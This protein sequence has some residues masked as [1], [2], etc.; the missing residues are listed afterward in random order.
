MGN[1][2]S[3]PPQHSP[4][5]V[6]GDLENFAFDRLLNDGKFMKSALCTYIPEGEQ[7]IVKIYAKRGR[8]AELEQVKRDLE[9]LAK[10]CHLQ[11]AP[12]LIPYQ[13]VFEK[14]VKR[15]SYAFLVRQHFRHN[16]CDRLQTRPVL[17]SV[18]KVW[19]VYQLLQ[20]VRQS[21]DLG[22]AHGDIKSENIV[23]TSW[24]WLFLTDFAVFKP[25]YLTDDNPSDY[26]YFF[27][28]E[29]RRCYLAP[30]R[31]V[32]PEH[33]ASESRTS[34]DQTEESKQTGNDGGSSGT[35]SPHQRS[36]AIGTRLGI[37]DKGWEWQTLD[38][39][40]AGCTIGEVMLGDGRRLFQ[41]G[42][43]LRYRKGELSIDDKLSDIKDSHA[44]V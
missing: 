29:R 2:H 7:V 8:R 33:G 9:V 31:F 12:N 10:R 37:P 44:R 36:G 5:D 41:Y 24:G 35:H 17:S 42:E 20:A 43:L 3:S 25:F 30:E 16:L 13:Q 26:V 40:S 27:D 4:V 19:L 11:L 38:I 32:S 18:E 39:F 14:T 15:E 21:Q 28:P 22:I 1:A 6:V 23:I 34:P